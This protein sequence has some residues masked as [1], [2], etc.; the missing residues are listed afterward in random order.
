MEAINRT[1]VEHIF[2]YQPELKPLVGKILNM[3]THEERS[4][5]SRWYIIGEDKLTPKITLIPFNLSVDLTIIDGVIHYTAPEKKAR[6]F[7]ELVYKQQN[8]LILTLVFFSAAF[9][10]PYAAKITIL[11]EAQDLDIPLFAAHSEIDILALYPGD[12]WNNLFSSL[13]RISSINCDFMTYRMRMIF[14]FAKDVG[15]HICN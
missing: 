2:F 1:H 4:L 5:L 15:I 13:E 10:I 6:L 7:K 9:F 12:E 14:G 3:L 11:A 8:F